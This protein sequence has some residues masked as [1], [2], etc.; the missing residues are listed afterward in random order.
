MR[1]C[2]NLITADPAGRRP[3][4]RSWVKSGHHAPFSKARVIG[5]T[6]NREL[7]AGCIRVSGSLSFRS[8]R[9]CINL[10]AEIPYEEMTLASLVR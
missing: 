5:V 2:G 10:V 1:S 7:S 6:F 8:G 3:A 4:H 9:A